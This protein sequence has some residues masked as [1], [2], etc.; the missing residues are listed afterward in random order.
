MIEDFRNHKCDL[1]GIHIGSGTAGICNG[2]FP[3]KADDPA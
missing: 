1:I 3:E 2:H